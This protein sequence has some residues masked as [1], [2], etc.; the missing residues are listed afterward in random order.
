MAIKITH[1]DTEELKK[2]GLGLEKII[3]KCFFCQEPTRYWS[4]KANK[5]VC[6]NCA[7]ER[8]I[9]ELPKKRKKKNE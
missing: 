6:S 5:P 3:E 1:E 9:S 8:D 2:W 7:K 4:K